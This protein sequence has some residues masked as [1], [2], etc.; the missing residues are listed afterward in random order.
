MSAYVGSS[1]NLKDLKDDIQDSMSD[2]RRWLAF[3]V[4]FALVVH[5]RKCPEEAGDTFKEVRSFAKEL[6]RQVRSCRS[7][8]IGRQTGG[9]ATAR[10]R[11]RN[12]VLLVTAKLSRQVDWHSLGQGRGVESEACHRLCA[13]LDPRSPDPWHAIGEIYRYLPSPGALSAWCSTQ[14]LVE[15]RLALSGGIPPLHMARG[16]IRIGPF[17]KKR[18]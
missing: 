2:P 14:M 17:R 15:P 13:E 4:I 11:R 7:D 10:C 9:D 8:R 6:Q 5:A 16:A 3:L 18:N 12:I 1:K